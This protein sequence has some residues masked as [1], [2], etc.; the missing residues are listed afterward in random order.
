MRAISC[1]PCLFDN[2]SLRA[3]RPPQ[4]LAPSAHGLRVRALPSLTPL[5]SWHRP[6]T[7]YASARFLPSL[8]SKVVTVRTR[9]T[10]PRA[11]FPPSPQKLP[12]SARLLPTS[13]IL[14]SVFNCAE[15]ECR[16][17]HN[18]A[19]AGNLTS[20]SSDPSNPTALKTRRCIRDR[21]SAPPVLLY[22]FDHLLLLLFLLNFLL[23][24]L[25]YRGK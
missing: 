10:R 24:L 4:K 22:L 16:Y 3:P 18:I 7:G 23:L 12:P 11:C 5:K 13:P 8:P 6:H 15:N 2:L 25:P 14:P 20:E 21:L 1:S 17:Q 9:A 19:R